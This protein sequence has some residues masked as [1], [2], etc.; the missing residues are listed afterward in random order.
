MKIPKVNYAAVSNLGY[1]P[2][3]GYGNRKM[4]IRLMCNDIQIRCSQLPGQLLNRT[5]QICS[6]LPKLDSG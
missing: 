2:D 3:N 4:L 5:F 6:I 1:I